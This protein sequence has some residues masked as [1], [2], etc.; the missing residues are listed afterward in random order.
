[1]GKREKYDVG[2]LSYNLYTSNNY[3]AVLHS[4]A[5]QQYL[6]KVGVKNVI[7]DYRPPQRRFKWLFEKGLAFMIRSLKFKLFFRKH[8]R[9]TKKTYTYNN[10]IDIDYINRYVCETDVTWSYNKKYGFD[11]GFFCDFKNMKYND[12][13]AYSV[14]FGSN[15]FTP[16]A[17]EEFKH[18]TKNFKY[19]AIRN[20][21]KLDY[22]KKLTVRN[23]IEVAVDPVFLLEKE[24]YR[25]I[26][27][28]PR[29]KKGYVLVYNCVENNSSLLKT[30]K[31]FAKE[32]NLKV[33]EL[34][35]FKDNNI[36]KKKVLT[37]SI[38]DFLGYI[39]GAEYVF[40]NSYHGIC[41][42]VLFNKQFYAF[43][44]K[45][46]SE[47]I[48][49]VLETFGLQDR[50]YDSE[51]GLNTTPIDYDKVIPEIERVVKGSKEFIKKSLVDNRMQ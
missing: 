5:F 19:I 26:M 41:F 30:A 28:L 21:F 37:A 2:I 10:I 34:S 46:N 20:N 38:E 35:L 32:N 51:S 31:R 43:A 40:T 45:G 16:E 25:K 11:R 39:Y 14:D 42:S 13:V 50:L 4:Y 47:K 9:K 3:G 48:Q 1:M 15:L 18:L 27:N 17:E 24:D 6:D 36:I 33:I 44:R 12:N 22:V 7:V 23:D 49:S 8:Y 29:V